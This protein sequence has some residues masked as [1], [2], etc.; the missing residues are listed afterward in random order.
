ARHGREALE[1][2]AQPHHNYQ[3]VLMD[4]QMPE[5]DGFETTRCIRQREQVEG[6]HISII[7]MTAQAM[8]GDR[9]RCLAAGMDDYVSKPVRMADLS[10]VLVRWLKVETV[11]D[12]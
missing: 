6:G 1:R 7:A 4:C 9:E 3:L 2:L 10:Q 12:R 11:P 8:K 5:M